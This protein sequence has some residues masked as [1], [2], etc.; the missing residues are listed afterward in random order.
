MSIQTL[1]EKIK[2][3]GN[4]TVAG[5]DARL[6]Y[7]PQHISGRNMMLHGETLRA[8]AESVVAFNCGLIDALCD[9]VPAVKPQAAYYELLGSYGAM[10]LKETIDYAHAKGMYVIGDIK[11]NDI[12]ATATAYA[13]AY[14]G[15]TRVG[16][17]EIAPYGCDSVTVNGYL[18]TDGVEP[19]L[20]ECRNREKSLFMLVKTS[21]PSSGELQNRDMEGKPLYARMAEMVAKWGEGLDTP[22][23]YNQIGA[24][25]GAQ[26]GLQIGKRDGFTLQ[27]LTLEGISEEQLQWQAKD[28]ESTTRGISF[29]MP[30]HN[31]T[32]TVNWKANGSSSG[33][34]GG[35][36]G[37]VSI[38]DTKIPTGIYEHGTVTVSP[39][40][41]S[42]GDTVTIT[43]TPDKGYDLSGIKVI[44]QNGREVKLTDKG[45]GKYTFTMPAGKITVKVVFMDDNTMLNFFTDVHAEDYYYDAVLWA[46]QKGITGGMS[47][48]LFAPNA[49]CTRAQIVTFLWRTAGSPESSALSN[50]N[51][52]PADKY[53]AKA[54]AWA[55]ENGI[56][57]GTTDTTFSPDD[58]CTRAHGVTFLYR[59]AKATASVGASAFT[60]VAD[61]AYYA[62]AVKWAT[63]QGITK[64]IS[65]T[66]FGLDETCTRAQIVTFL[67]RMYQGK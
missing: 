44:D 48:T 16:D 12:G 57:N 46:A 14:L 61:S 25:V 24:V 63:E 32:V 43:A 33:G 3:K 64:D 19:F 17:T 7:I 30:A 36:G 26:V 55:V 29:E 34:G 42:K 60:D 65:S 52:V 39:E 11:R 51:D 31:V 6:E 13:E 47:D 38:P 22:C 67:Y 1:V 66:L 49:A 41:A 9:I 58:I 53:Y 4:P 40:S 21:N 59:A 50:F 56:T 2:E 54:V 8:A 5:L 18:G 20:K 10:A 27:G 35:G 28:A 45:S 15:K 23:G 37:S 62:D